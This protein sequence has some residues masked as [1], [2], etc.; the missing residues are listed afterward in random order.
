MDIYDSRTMLAAIIRMDK[1][2]RVFLDTFVKG[3]ENHQ[4]EFIDLDSYRSERAIAPFINPLDEATRVKLANYSTATMQSPYIREQVV[5]NPKDVLP[6]QMG[7]T[8]YGPRSTIAKRA[9]VKL[10]EALKELHRRFITTQEY[11]IAQALQTGIIPIVGP[12][13]NAEIDLNMLPTHIETLTGTD[14]WTDTSNSDPL[15]DL[16]LWR[17]LCE[18]DSGLTPTVVFM[19]YEAVSALLKHTDIKEI[20]DNRRMELGQIKFESKPSGLTRVGTLEEFDI[21]EYNKTYRDASGTRQRFMNSKKVVLGST[22]AK[23][24]KHFGPIF[25][26]HAEQEVDVFP[27]SWIPDDGSCRIVQLE[28]SPLPMIHEINAF[29]VAQVVA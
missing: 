17:R 4:T 20:L 8:I 19:G 7:E 14:L 25:N 26:M 6:R 29:F 13:I 5:L 18:D 1:I 10:G 22:D 12:N 11:M 2:C 15:G 27:R 28:G 24:I 9:Q 3:K 23:G 21:Y 16:R